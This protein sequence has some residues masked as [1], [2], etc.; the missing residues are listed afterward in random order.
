MI[1]PVRINAGVAFWNEHAETLARAEQEFGV[2]AEIIV[3]IMGVETVYGRNTG[4]FRVLD[5]LTTLAFAYP[6]TPNRDAR[7]AF[8]RN[9]LENAL[10][11]ARKNSS[12]RSPCSAPSRARSACRN[13]CPA[14]CSPMA[15]ITTTTAR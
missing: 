5:V 13:S 4:R 7:M 6:E 8:F 2:P 1:E 12:I 10:L 9:E 11:L 15:S 14:A 3:G